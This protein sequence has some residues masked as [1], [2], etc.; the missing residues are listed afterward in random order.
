[1][2]LAALALFAIA[3]LGIWGGLESIFLSMGSVSTLFFELV[4]FLYGIF[5]S[6]FI[7]GYYCMLQFRKSK[8]LEFYEDY[9]RVFPS[10]WG[11]SKNIRYTEFELG[12]IFA[13]PFMTRFKFLSIDIESFRLIIDKEKSAMVGCI[14]KKVRTA[15]LDTDLY[16]WL[17]DEKGLAKTIPL[18]ISRKRASYMG[19]IAVLWFVT[20]F[21][22]III[23][24]LRPLDWAVLPDFIAFLSSSYLILCNFLFSE[25]RIEFCEDHFWI[26]SSY[27]VNRYSYSDV[28][29][30]GEYRC[31]VVERFGLGLSK[32]IEMY[33]LRLNGS[34]K[35]IK[36]PD[37]SFEMGIGKSTGVVRTQSRLSVDPKIES[38]V[39]NVYL[40]DLLAKKVG[41]DKY[42][43][44]M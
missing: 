12:L 31:T 34:R 20:G 43:Q 21:S 1:M 26:S 11:E 14:N 8:R 4:L 44:A 33:W 28:E 39:P 9:V 3:I 16:S 22:P 27:K 32:G 41:N 35:K 18:A 30:W 23:G 25:S 17:K 38:T 6:T 7:T 37:L 10:L 15:N 24:P 2:L 40:D 42:D 36:F 29:R 5:L 13:I 19:I